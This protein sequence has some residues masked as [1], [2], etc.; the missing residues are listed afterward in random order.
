M[1]VLRSDDYKKYLRDRLASYKIEIELLLIDFIEKSNDFGEQFEYLPALYKQVKNNKTLVDYL[2]SD[3]VQHYLEEKKS[4]AAL[5]EQC[6]YGY[7]ACSDFESQAAAYFRF[8]INRSVSR[9]IEKNELSDEEIEALI[10][11]GD[12]EKAFALTQNVFL[13]EERLK[14]LLIIAQAG[15]HLSDSMNK[16]LNTQIET[17]AEVIDYAHI[18][19]KALELAKL[20]MP[21]NMQKALDIIDKVA[22]VTKDQ[23]QIDRLYTAISLSY[24]NEGKADDI[25]ASKADIVS[26]RIADEGLKK[27]ASVMK[28]IMKDSTAQQ[29]VARMKELPTASSQLYFLR[30]WIPNHKKQDDIGDVVEYAVKLVVES[31]TTTMPKVTYLRLFCKPLPDM[32]EAQ[33]KIVVELLDAVVANIKYPTVEYIRLMILVISAVGKYNKIDAKNRLQDLYLEILDFKDKGLQAHC[34]ALILHDFDKLGAKADIEQWLSSFDD[35]QREINKDL[36]DVLQYAAYHMKVVEGP[37][38]ALVCTA[39]SLVRNVIA[40]MNTKERKDKAYVLAAT[41]YVRQ[42]DITHF[43]WEYFKELFY[44]ITYDKTELYKP[45][46]EL[47]QKII[48][49]NSKD[50]MLLCNVKKN[51]S[52]F[53]AIEQVE[54]MCYTFASLYVWLCKNY[55]KEISF[56]REVKG[57]METCWNKISIPWLQIN[58]GYNIAKEL[59]KISLKEEAREYVAKTTNIRKS[60]LLSS[61]SCVAA[62]TESVNIYVH[63]LGILIRSGICTE[64]DIEQFKTLMEYDNNEADTIIMWSR[65]ALEYYG[66][67]NQEWFDK[68]MNNYVSRPLDKFS[69]YCQKRV[70]FQISPALYL[71]SRV[72][73]YTR[74]NEFDNNFANACIENIARY[75]QT[76]YPY[77][78]YTSTNSIE[79][80][81]PLEK[82]DYD[83]LL[84]LMENVQDDGFIFS[85]TNIITSAIKHNLGSKL[86]REIQKVLLDKLEDIVTTRLPMTDCIQHDGYKIACLTMIAWSRGESIVVDKLKAQIEGIKNTADQ[87]FLYALLAN[88]LKK[89]SEKTDFIELALQKTESINYTFDR[90][91]RYELCIQETFHAVPARAHSVA[92]KVMNSLKS[93]NNG[94]YHDYQRM[95]DMVRDHDEALADSM[96]EMI[97]DDPARLQYK[98]M[99]KQRATSSKKIEAAKNNLLLVSRLNNDEQIR[100]F[101]RQMEV[102]IKKKNVVRDF[103]TTQAIIGKIYENPITDTQNAVLYF[104]ENLYQ[105]NAANGKYK[106][107]LRN[108]HQAILYNLKLVLAIAS[109]TQE[110]M[111]RVNRIMSER[112]DTNDGM[113]QVGREDKGV[114]KILEWYKKYPHDILRIIDPHFHAKDL[115]IIKLL[116]D[117]NNNLKCFILTKNETQEPLNEIF[118]NG[119]NM[120]SAEL[121]GRIEVKACC[122]EDQQGKTPFHDRWWLLYN[123][124]TDEYQGI[125]M[126]SP[127]T[128]GSRI[129]EISSM[130][131][132][133]I[134]SAMNIFNKFFLNMI[135]KI[136]GRK[137]N[138]E[139][140]ILR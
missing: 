126:A 7:N 99:L 41:E 87:A 121:P 33:I 36:S 11:I 50:P 74:L 77:P 25:N 10:A 3:N 49:E 39:P 129:T 47:L 14:C 18:P 92:T 52:L 113:I 44:Q 57:D 102:L 130:D 68:I 12:D 65:I 105:K 37:I 26:T 29:V 122:Y 81:I 95:L 56:Q 128:L 51:Y 124:N 83:N 120:I 55:D 61:L 73:L 86:S 103:N 30:Y 76:K 140:T 42:T 90:F 28:Q 66:V 17:L 1:I 48:D 24:S 72:L 116:M 137:L 75:I 80:Q 69:K 64:D 111:D 71:S 133:A 43:N 60:Q 6:E 114:K 59:S 79:A 63:S 96:L 94:S 70:L 13:L 132:E 84:D 85:Y 108:I 118:Q 134:H 139:E 104:I 9:E 4:Q 16:E 138:Y 46:L 21:I 34:K 54:L 53:K 19:D 27:M 67:N 109:G 123:T 20:M 40:Q 106:I 135:P 98:K 101:D 131:S 82:K 93:E 62:Y 78:E 22:K 125:R 136:E 23:Q 38:K 35:L 112:Y 100:F 88:Y 31:S 110:K 2:T 97:D 115:F 32:P 119:W 5:N 127:S 107:L 8:A 89:V 117:I 15:M 58:T 45:I 91:N